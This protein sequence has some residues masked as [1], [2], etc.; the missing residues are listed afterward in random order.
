MKIVSALIC[1]LVIMT[2]AII[3][4]RGAKVPPETMIIGVRKGGRNW[5]RFRGTLLD[6]RVEAYDFA[7]LESGEII[8]VNTGRKTGRKIITMPVKK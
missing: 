3:T 8:E 5:V 7:A 6:A 4:R 1:L 2:V